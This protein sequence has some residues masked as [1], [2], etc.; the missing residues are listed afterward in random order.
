MLDST[1]YQ[2]NQHQAEADYYPPLD[3]IIHLLSM[4]GQVVCW[5]LYQC[6]RNIRKIRIKYGCFAVF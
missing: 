1:I 4:W 2:I 6:K 3:S 5:K